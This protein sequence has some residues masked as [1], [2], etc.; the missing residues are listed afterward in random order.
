M[1]RESLGPTL[2]LAVIGM[3]VG[4]GV[5]LVVVGAAVGSGVGLVVVG[6]AVG[7]GVGSEMGPDVAKEGGMRVLC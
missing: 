4:C 5:G 1:E 6:A 3:A 7:A 2:G